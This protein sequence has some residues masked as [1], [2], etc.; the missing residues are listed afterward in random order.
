MIFQDETQ[1]IQEFGWLDE[2][3]P[4]NTTEQNFARMA[5][6]WSLK[7]PENLWESFDG[8]ATFLEVSQRDD[9]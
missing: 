9:F 8:Q 3:L 1:N 7:I 4:Q 6:L 2:N 5:Y